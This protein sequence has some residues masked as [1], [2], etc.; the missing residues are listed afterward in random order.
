MNPEAVHLYIF[1][2]P[3]IISTGLLILALYDF[4]TEVDRSKSVTTRAIMSI[5]SMVA[6]QALV[7]TFI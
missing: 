5:V 1:S 4:M 7:F 6:A 2:V 3:L